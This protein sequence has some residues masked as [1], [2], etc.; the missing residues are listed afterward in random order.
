MAKET[1][2]KN[3]QELEPGSQE[4]LD[5]YYAL[6]PQDQSAIFNAQMDPTY[7]EDAFNFEEGLAGTGAYLPMELGGNLLGPQIDPTYQALIQFGGGVNIPQLTSA[8]KLDPY[9]LGQEQARHNLMQDQATAIADIILASLA[10]PGALDPASFAPIETMPTNRISM[11]GATQ[12]DRYAQG[13]GYKGYIARKIRDENKTDDEAIADLFNFLAQP[14]E[15][16]SKQSIDVRQEII[17][18]LPS[19]MKAGNEIKTP[20][21]QG[22][23]RPTQ[24]IRDQFDELGITKWA[25][26]IYFK[27]AD[28]VAN[29]QA[30]WQDPKTGF[31]YDQAPTYEDSP[32]TTKFKNLGLPSPFAAY[33]DPQYLQMAM[34]AYAPNAEASSQDYA[35]QSAR[36]AAEAERTQRAAMDVGRRNT[37][38]QAEYNRAYEPPGPRYPNIGGM[39]ENAAVAAPVWQQPLNTTGMVRDKQG[40]Y[41]PMPVKPPIDIQQR[42]NDWMANATANAETIQPSYSAEPTLRPGHARSLLANPAGG[43]DFQ[44]SLQDAQG[45]AFGNRLLG[46]VN[47]FNKPMG[48]TKVEKLS[49]AT[50]KKSQQDYNRARTAFLKANEDRFRHSQTIT[51]DQAA[52]ID[53]YTAAIHQARQGRTPFVD[54]VTQRLLGQRAFGVRG[55]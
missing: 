24:D 25:N 3:I 27:Y 50:A 41:V 55:G 23:G 20:S 39:L 15:G 35:N 13:T 29:M 42:F 53:A 10:G 51:P 45:K 22:T 44:Q 34:D 19:E 8:G 30:G 16:V 49:P 11:P 14:E 1:K 17:D 46:N 28:D 9:D 5:A 7:N 43:Y 21:E 12:I 31:W 32:A 36:L 40:N 33:D 47:M 2:P 26:D 52:A 48:G 38:L 37:E 6:S 54:A 4:W 18:S